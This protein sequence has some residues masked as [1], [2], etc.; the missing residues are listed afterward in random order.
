MSS[1][2][3]HPRAVLV[4][5]ES[6][7][8]AF[9][10]LYGE[11]LYSHA[12]RALVEAAGPV[13]VAVDGPDLPRVRTEVERWR[14]P[15]H[16][17]T[18]DEHWRFLRDGPGGSLLVHDALCPLVTSDFLAS[19]AQRS[20]D[21]PEVSFVAVRA[22]TDT[23]KAVVDGHI[24]KTIDRDGLAAVTSPLVVS[25]DVLQESVDER[26]PLDD[27]VAMVD[28][29]RERGEV[30]LVRAP[31]L[32]RRVEHARSV[33]LLECMDEVGRRVRAEAGH[34]GVSQSSVPEDRP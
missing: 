12:L 26:P 32:G 7:G 13:V 30:Q 21:E 27:F 20:G 4:V 17:L 34:Q 29:L 24:Q 8:P 10:E 31:S 28:W 9:Q 2:T 1:A 6:S 16:V 14:I 3:G 11:P 22:V 19:M 25:G 5:S 23:L 18:L 33:H 15:A